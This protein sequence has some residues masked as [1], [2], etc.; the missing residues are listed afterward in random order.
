MINELDKKILELFRYLIISGTKHLDKIDYKNCRLLYK[1]DDKEISLNII[2]VERENDKETPNSYST[3]N[4]FSSYI[5][6]PLYWDIIN[7]SEC[8]L[9][10]SLTVEGKVYTVPK[11]QRIEQ[12]QTID[13]IEAILE[14]KESEILDSVLNELT[15]DSREEL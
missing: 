12:A 5:G 7:V 9:G 14:E 3:L 8:D 13:R 2:H 15:S 6:Y 11:L 4:I 10:F 1:V